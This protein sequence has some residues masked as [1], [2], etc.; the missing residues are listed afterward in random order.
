MIVGHGI[1][2]EELSGF[3]V[4]AGDNGWLARCFLDTELKTL[5]EV[6]NNTATIAG[7]FC[8]KEAVLKALGTGQGAGISFRDVE[9]RHETSGQPRVCLQNGAK[10]IADALGV[11]AWHV[12]ISHSAHWVVASAIA[13]KA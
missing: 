2:V 10:R 6:T 4:Y 1:D 13:E 7:R 5:D 3:D 11:T 12:S 9:I 8:L